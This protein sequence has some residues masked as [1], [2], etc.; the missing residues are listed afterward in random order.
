VGVGKKKREGDG[1]KY[2]GDGNVLLHL[3]LIKKQVPGQN[4]LAGG[5]I[6]T[7]SSSQRRGDLPATGG[8]DGDRRAGLGFLSQDYII[9]K[10][11][12][13]EDKI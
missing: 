9:G 7:W 10:T 5:E 2:R 6:C 12:V 3:L 11:E 13:K 1:L 4:F 8:R